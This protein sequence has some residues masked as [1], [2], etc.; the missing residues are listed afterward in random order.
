MITPAI[1]TPDQRVAATYE[2][3]LQGHLDVRWADRLDLASLTHEGDGTTVMRSLSAD[4]SALHG[5]LQRIRDLG[6]PLV[7][8]TRLPFATDYLPSHSPS[9]E[10]ITK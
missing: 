1:S 8:V 6:L 7:S 9:K 2:V 5:L 4:Q 10:R 3:R